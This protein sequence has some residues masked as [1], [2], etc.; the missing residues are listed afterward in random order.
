MLAVMSREE[1]MASLRTGGADG[2]Q[3]GR[4]RETVAETGAGS[5]MRSPPNKPR[6]STTMS[7]GGKTGS[8]MKKTKNKI[9]DAPR[10]L[11]SKKSPAL[12]CRGR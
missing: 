10:T 12:N 5:E 4:G 9:L 8:T 7:A 3:T 11:L 2:S 6:G 1:G